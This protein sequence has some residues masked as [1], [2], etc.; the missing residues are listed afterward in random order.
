MPQE[1][2]T[3]FLL[4]TFSAL[5]GAFVNH[6]LS[7]DR[8]MRREFNEAANVFRNIFEG[9]LATIHQNPDL[10]DRQIVAEI[11]IKNYPD[12]RIAMGS[13]SRQ[14]WYIKKRAFHR[15]WQEYVNPESRNDEPF[16]SYCGTAWE[17]G[18]SFDRKYIIKSIERLISF[19]N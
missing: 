1:I 14:M 11:L 16:L 8:D 10:P 13:L 9:I 19:A 17:V 6:L 15:A 7:K 5:L 4:G 3:A 2:I 12:Q 18:K